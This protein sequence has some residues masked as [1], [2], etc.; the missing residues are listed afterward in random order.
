MESFFHKLKTELVYHLPTG[1]NPHLMYLPPSKSFYNGSRRHSAF[2]HVSPIE[3]ALKEA[4][5]CRS[6]W[7][8]RSLHQ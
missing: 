4:Y 6:F 2:G 7:G 3:K 1:S 5:P 8:G